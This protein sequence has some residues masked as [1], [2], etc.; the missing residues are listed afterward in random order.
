MEYVLILSYILL[1]DVTS[2]RIFFFEAFNLQDATSGHGIKISLANTKSE[3]L[4]HTVINDMLLT[5]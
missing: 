3:M 4:G 1:K 2:A 5:C